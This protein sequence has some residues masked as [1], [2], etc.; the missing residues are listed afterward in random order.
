MVGVVNGAGLGLNYTSYTGTVN[1]SGVWNQGGLGLRNT[2][3]F[4]NGY[5]GN[6]IVQDQD[7]LLAAAGT[8]LRALRTYNSRGSFNDDNGD[9]W[10]TGVV[11]QSMRL[12]AGTWGAAGSTVLVTEEDGSERLYTWV[13]NRYVSTTSSG[14]DTYL[15]L[16][17]D[18]TQAVFS[19]GPQSGTFE[20]ATGRLLNWNSP[21]LLN[22]VFSYNANG[23]LAGMSAD[24]AGTG[25]RIVYEYNGDRLQRVSVVDEQN[26]AVSTTLYA[27]DANGRLS[28]VTV[29][30]SPSDGTIADGKVYTTDYT[31]VSSTDIT[32]GMLRSIVN[33]DGTSQTFKWVVSEGL[34]R[35]SQSW[36]GDGQIWSY[37]YSTSA[38]TLRVTQPGGFTTDFWYDG[39]G[40][41][42]QSHPSKGANNGV[43]NDTIRTFLEYYTTDNQATFT[44]YDRSVTVYNYD[45]DNNLILVRDAAGNTVRR[46][47]VNR[48]V[49]TETFYAVADPDGYGT[50]QPAGPATTRYVYDAEGKLRF[51]LS[52]EGAVT[53]LRYT[54]KLPTSTISYLGGAYNVSA[55]TITQTPTEAQMTTW[56]NG[57][58]KS[59]TSRVD[60]V[61]DLRGQKLRETAYAATDSS[62]NG[63][64]SGQ[65]VVVYAYDAA[66]RLL[67]MTDGSDASIT[68]AYDGLGRVL[69]RQ[70]GS[71]TTSYVHQDGGNGYVSTVTEQ[72]G[73]VTVSTYDK[74]G[75]LL[76]V[77][78]TQNGNALGTSTNYYNARG[79]LYKTQD[80]TGVFHW[81]LYDERANKVAEVDGNGTVTE[82]RYD[83]SQRPIQTIVYATPLAALSGTSPNLAW[84]DPPA[85][86][87]LAS[88]RPAETAKDQRSWTLYD[89]A[90]RP[91]R[92]VDAAG[93]VTE[94]QYDG[95]GRVT[96]T[97]RYANA[98]DLASFAANPTA[99][100]ATPAANADSDR[101]S[102]KFYSTEGRLLADLDAEGFLVEY[103]YDAA[104][105]LS[106]TVRYA[107][108]TPATLR[109]AGTL[110]Q[111]RPT[112]ASPKDQTTRYVYDGQSRVIG[113]I[114]AEG[115]VTEQLYDDR[116]HLVQRTRYAAKL[117]AA[118][119][120]AF[121][122][123]TGGWRPA[124][125][126]GV[127]GDRTE[128]W[129]YNTLGQ[130][131]EQTDADG[132]VTRRSYDNAG[133][134]ISTTRA[135]G[136]AEARTQKVRYDAVGRVVGELSARGA[137]L[138]VDGQTQAQVDA[139]W[140]QYGT[141]Y[142]Y[143]AAGRRTSQIVS[144]GTS[145]QRTIFFYNEDDQVTH[146]INA[147]GEVTENQYDGLGQLVK[148]VAYG[149]RLGATTLN[150]L[151]GGLA[152]AAIR[153]AVQ[154]LLA[155]RTPG[156][157]A[158][159]SAQSVFDYDARGLLRSTTNAL[160]YSTS[161]TYNAFGQA[162]VVS[163]QI[164]LGGALVQGK[165][166]YDRRGVLVAT[167]ADF[168]GLN[169]IT[170]T[171]VD[172]FGRVYEQLD[173]RGVLTKTGYDRLGRVV[174]TTDGVLVN[175]YTSYD[176][177][178]R[179]V[180]TTDGNGQKTTYRYDVA[181][182]TVEVTTPEGIRSRVVR[183]RHGEVESRTDG[184]NVTTSYAYTE[185]GELKT[186]TTP[187]NGTSTR[188]DSLG[189]VAE[190][191]DANGTVTKYAYDDLNRITSRTV[192][193]AGLNLITGYV[194]ED[195]DTGTTVLT[196]EADGRQT[197]QNF[198]VAGRLVSS[199]VDPSGLALTTR[200]ELDAEGRT[201]KVID[202]N[203]IVTRYE[204]DSLGRRT[205]EITDD[206]DSVSDLKLTRTYAYDAAG[207]LAWST[208]WAGARTLY[209]YDDANRLVYE[210][211]P[212]G[213]VR[214]TEYDGED[215][216]RRVARLAT[217]LSAANLTALGTQPTRAQIAALV[218]SA[219]AK[220]EISGRIYD[221]DGRVKYSVDAS[222]TVVEFRYDRAGRVTQQT[223]YATPVADM[224]AWMDGGAAAPT[225][226]V[227][228]R[229]TSTQ[230]D[231]LGR[232][233]V[234]VDAEG[235]VSTMVYD[236]AGNLQLRTSFAQPL[237]AAQQATLRGLGA[238]WDIVTLGL[239]AAHAQDR[240]T[241]YRYDSAGRPRY[242]YDAEGYVN[243]TR[244]DGL[245]TTT[246]R[247][248]EKAAV[249]VEPT[250]GAD[251]RTSLVELDK[252][253]RVLRS[254]DAMGVE[255]RNAYDAGGRLLA[256]TQAYGLAEATTT[257]YAYD[258]AGHVLRKTV[259]SGTGAA[260]TTGY[261][262]DSVGRMTTETEARGIAL[263]E[264][265]ETWARTERQRLGYAQ[266]VGGLSDT[267]K[268]T[269]LAR[270]TTTH[271]YDVAGRRKLTVNAMGFRTTTDYDAFG[272]AVKVTDPA[273]NAGYFYF[274]KLNRVTLQVDPEG[275]AT[276]TTYWGAGSSRVATVR[277]YFNKVGAPVVGQEPTIEEHAKDATTRHQYDRLDRTVLST[278][279][280]G[281]LER[282]SYGVDGN[283]FDKAVTN[284]ADG[285]AVYRTDRLGR[286]VS[287]TLPVSVLGQAVVNAYGY[288]AFDRTSS[289]EAVKPQGAGNDWV[290]RA[291]T[292][293]YDKAGRLTHRI[294]TGYEATDAATL[295]RST[296]VPVEFTR[297]D[298][299]GRVIET[300]QR[301][302][303]QSASATVVG[304]ARTLSYYDAASGKIAQVGADGAVTRFTLDVAG[305]VV[306]ESAFATRIAQPGIAG[307]QA[308]E[309]PVDAVNDRHTRQIYDALGR[310][311]LT[312]RENV[313]YW[314]STGVNDETLMAMRY[315]EVVTLK[316]QVYDAN[317][318]VVQEKDGRGGSIYNYY[319]STG[320][321]VLRID[322]AGYA[323]AWEF[324]DFLDVASRELKYAGPVPA[325]ARQD[326]TSAAVA[327]R[328][329]A[330]IRAGLSLVDAR[331]TDFDLDRLGR[332]SEKRVL[333][334]ETQYV[335]TDG[336]LR[337]AVDTA[338]T[339][340][341]YD[342]L[343]NITQIRERVAM[344][345]TGRAE[346]WAITD[347]VRDALGRETS[348]KA[349]RFVD[350]D[351]IE[352][353]QVT[354]TEYDGLGNARRVIQRGTIDVSE[355]DDRISRFEYNVNG[356]KVGEVDAAGNYTLYALDAMGN[357][358]TSTRKGVK[359]AD[360]S[361]YDI[362]KT[363]QYDVTGR[364][365]A[366]TDLA[367]S[368]V[369]KTRYNAFG[370]VTGKGLGDGWQE[371][372]EYSTL[373]KLQRGNSE[374]GIYKIHL[375]D[376]NGNAT[377]EISAGDARD[378][379]GQPI[380][381][382]VLGIATAA[383]DKRLNHSFSLYDARNLRTKT[384]EIGVSYLKNEQSKSF[385]FEQ[386]LADLYGQIGIKN[387]GGG[388]YEGASPTKDESG[389]KET[390]V[391]GA[392]PAPLIKTPAS[393]S[394]SGEIW[395]VSPRLQ[396]E[397][398]PQL[399]MPVGG[400]LTAPA[401]TTTTWPQNIYFGPPS[402]R[403]SITLSPQAPPL[404]GADSYQIIEKRSSGNITPFNVTPGVPVSL[405]GDRDAGTNY[406]LVAQYGTERVVLSELNVA[407]PYTAR[408]NNWE[409]TTR[410]TLKPNALMVT[411]P[412]A[413]AV[414]LRAYRMEGD[415]PIDISS[416]IVRPPVY[417][418]YAATWPQSSTLWALN[419][420]GLPDG[421]HT[422]VI[423]AED[424][425]GN[426]IA[427]STVTANYTRANGLVPLT[428]TAINNADL[429]VSGGSLTFK[430]PFRPDQPGDQIFMRVADHSQSYRALNN[431]GGSASISEMG[432]VNGAGYEMMIAKGNG[433]RYYVS[434]TGRNVGG[435]VVPDFGNSARMRTATERV[436]S[437]GSQL[438]FTLAIAPVDGYSLP[439]G[440]Q[441]RVE[442]VIG[443]KAWNFST[444]SATFEVSWQ[445][446]KD[447]QVPVN[448]L[449][450]NDIGFEY[451]V[452]GPRDEHEEWIG[453]SSGTLRA[454]TGP[455]AS[456]NPLPTLYVP[457]LSIPVAGLR[458][459][460][461]LTSGADTV[462]TYQ[463]T[464]GR[465]WRNGDATVLNLSDLMPAS[466]TA[467]Y[468]IT[469]DSSD[470]RFTGTVSVRSD[471]LAT[472]SLT[473]ATY[474]QAKVVLS[475]PYG[476]R[477]TR[478]D[479]GDSIL[480]LTNS[481]SRVPATGAS[482]FVWDVMRSEY[483]KTFDVYY[484]TSVG[485]EVSY[486]GRAKYSVDASGRV[487]F[488]A[489]APEFKLTYLS[490]DPPAET[491]SDGFQVEMRKRGS[492]DPWTSYTLLK[493]DPNSP[494][495]T[496]SLDISALRPTQDASVAYDFR[497]VSYA[498]GQTIV[499]K[500]AGGFVMYKDGTLI[501]DQQ[502]TERRP[503]PPTT[504]TGPAGRADAKTL[505]LSYTRVGTGVTTTVELTGAWNDTAKQM[506]YLWSAPMGGRVIES[507]EDYTFS[508]S[509]KNAGGAPLR[510]EVGDPI[511]YTGTLSVG[512]ARN[513][514]GMEMKRYVSTV[515]ASAKVEHRQTFNAFGEVAEEFD[516]RVFDRATAMVAQY[517]KDGLGTFAVNANAVRTVFKYNTLGQL[518]SKQ[519][520]ETFETLENGFVRRI[521]PLAQYGYD[522]L[523]RMT[524][525]T[526][527]NNHVSKQA[528]VGSSQQVAVQWAADN[529][530]R[531]TD[532]D[533][534]GDARKLTNELDK[535]TLQE[536]DQIGHLV[537][538]QR[539][540]ISRAENFSGAN[541]VGTV[542]TEEYKHDALGQ[543]IWHKDTLG[544]ED[545]TD[546]DTLSRVA[547]TW[548]AEG[549]ATRY[550]YRFVPAGASSDAVLGLGGRNVG[551]YVRKTISSDNAETTDKLDYFGRMT[552]HLDQG[553]RSYVYN[554]SLG[555]QLMSQT[556][557]G[558]QRIEYRY[559]LNG[560]LAEVRDYGVASTLNRGSLSRFGYDDAGNRTFEG[561]L[562]MRADGTEGVP[563]QAST[564]VY[565]ELNRI[566]RVHDGDFKSHD[567]RYEYDAV[568]NRRAVIATYWDPQTNSLQQRDD[569]WYTYD[570]AD[571]FTVTK[572]TLDRRGLSAGDTGT[573]ILLRTEGVRLTYDKAGQRTSA[574]QYSAALGR[575]ALEEYSYTADGYLEDTFID[576]VRR[577]RRRT[578]AEG[579][580]LQYLEWSA[581]SVPGMVKTSEYDKDN[582]VLRETVTGAK[583][584]SGLNGTTTFFYYGDYR[585]TNADAALSTGAGAMARA[586]F[587]DDKTLAYQAATSVTRYGYE[588]WDSAK[589]KWITQTAN[590]QTG[591]TNFSYDVN[592]H[593]SDVVDVEGGRVMTYYNNAQGMVL[594][595]TEAERGLNTPYETYFYYASGRRVGDVSTN[596]AAR[597]NRV[598]YAEQL[599]LK[600]KAP[601]QQQ[602]DYKRPAPV[603]SADFDQNY[604]PIN[605][606]YPSSVSSTYTV[607]PNDTLS[608]IAQSVWG[609]AAMWY[610]LAE[611]NGLSGSEVLVEGQVLVVPNKVTNIHNNAK[612]FRP[613]NPGEAIGNV[614]PTVPNPPPPPA[615]DKGCGAVGMALMIIVAVVVTV[616]TAGAGAAVMGFI[617]ATGT[618]ATI[619]A[620]A[621]SAALGA[622]A[623]QA[624]GMVTGDVDKFSWKAVGQAAL[625]AGVAAGV[626]SA[627]SSAAS[628]TGT[629]SS[630]SESA[631]WLGGRTLGATMARTAIS[632]AVT[633]AIQ[634]K[635]SWREVGASAVSAGAGYQAGLALQSVGQGM[636]GAEAIKN[637][638]GS[639]VGAWASSQVMGYNSAETRARLSQAFISGLGQ[640]IGNAIGDSIAEANQPAI[641]TL[642][643]TS[644]PIE[645]I[646]REDI[647]KLPQLNLQDLEDLKP[648]QLQLPASEVGSGGMSAGEFD[649]R[650]QS[651]EEQLRLE[652]LG[653][654]ARD[655]SVS[656][657]QMFQTG[658]AARGPVR[659]GI[660]NFE[661]VRNG[662]WD[663]ALNL[664]SDPLGLL[665][666]MPGIQSD[667]A[668]LNRIQ[669][670]KRIEGMREAMIGLGVKN[671]PSG[672]S[673][674]W[675]TGA[676]GVSKNVRD[677]GATMGQ[678]QGAY[679]GHVRDQRLRETWG[680]DYQNMRLGKSQMTVME[681]EKRVLDIQMATTDKAYAAGVDAI[682]RRELK[683][684]PGD[685]ARTLGSYI[686][687]Q[688]RRELRGFAR[689]EGINDNSTSNIWAI[690]RRITGEYGAG[691]PDNR[692]GFNLYSD[693]TLA[694]KGPW[695]EQIQ[696]WNWNRPGINLIIRPTDLGGAY[697][698]P[699]G[700]IPQ[701]KPLGRGI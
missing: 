540:G 554:Y 642:Q 410:V 165:F 97:V 691:I 550:E 681:F 527:A 257:A 296:V 471:G 210:I 180:D 581:S 630:V 470:A 343:G 128:F 230:Y 141:A 254:V 241:Q 693:T 395:T 73:L 464:D 277:R 334:V 118:Q 222:G 683:V 701:P 454:S 515:T 216:E 17:G 680:D 115:H 66:G 83:V 616:L 281:K 610:L 181:A 183:N 304:G 49:T 252:A 143:D 124:G 613:Y 122:A 370:E 32:N 498:A 273:G 502:T 462:R 311:V 528:F 627:I 600:E 19:N 324:K 532:Y 579:R 133:R 232:A 673:E 71:I 312:Q 104:G 401:P 558:G 204:Y 64:T 217:P 422:I 358:A 318:N 62:G 26:R 255:T 456:L 504:F 81:Y 260:S 72:N 439:P 699:R 251:D 132:T 179:V 548:S 646:T 597:K 89:A 15:T 262:Y 280:V 695:T 488:T 108:Q 306:K 361:T 369:R 87:T 639:T 314:E 647:G 620:A 99:V 151:S 75:R 601:V 362:V 246:I 497:Y 388:A 479:I 521:R 654:E 41:L 161:T 443:G 5:T 656:G 622:A 595:R 28:R 298:A 167:T 34:A 420:N 95:V 297:Y 697:V 653:Q 402:P 640:G 588:N 612:T 556:S 157:Q 289:V 539:L 418:Q 431:Y 346:V 534:F 7:G 2:Q 524:V 441:Y 694:R 341:D 78:R 159:A 148:T 144:D 604:E 637:A 14:P 323:I 585:D 240:T 263:T 576:G 223:A 116:G 442:A 270:F 65:H 397:N 88:I 440:K 351:G 16:S 545:R 313:W 168:G 287:E 384:V 199:T 239:P 542:V 663:A 194:Y 325:F 503:I 619:G 615:K 414:R 484:E 137:A 648:P 501:R 302:Q 211:D 23:S 519:D 564:I 552:W 518:I 22:A 189:R 55:L 227:N 689:A 375:Y 537:R 329:P 378:A 46:N 192:D 253:G 328:D 96:G 434:F 59:R 101:V 319:D 147:L 74:M 468:D 36:G 551:G 523:G 687:D 37:D 451:R 577:S 578:D 348:R 61:Y 4:I 310:L 389:L 9:N 221:R 606:G 48:L 53:E 149:G 438:K 156:N 355:T 452:Y 54:G 596:P 433:Q 332:V 655:A 340:Y 354:D 129:H 666:E 493:T 225:E 555:G 514:S 1:Q 248:A 651:V 536:F 466:G 449:S 465:R 207:R 569:F 559:L 27:Y 20:V 107:D 649:A 573:T 489:A 292:Y 494:T 226:G 51:K 472:A 6:L 625:S 427:A 68:Y 206:G 457:Y 8:D 391:G 506:E 229:V 234:T 700:S 547:A 219:P 333:N 677:Y 672:Y 114:D 644:T 220:D 368:E 383:E 146:T 191:T 77:T 432:L 158:Y 30:L 374:E 372:S 92:R 12:T 624:A 44:D 344:A 85:A 52:P 572:G 379:G 531:K 557:S 163:R 385:A 525:S 347:I 461:T 322:Q 675:V 458:G 594:K 307:G 283:R 638:L 512:G 453:Y 598:S 562:S 474:G 213:A 643:D 584:D 367:T 236:G 386:K 274:D 396:S 131:D 10:I 279:A 169:A 408:N 664:A 538:V 350:M 614:D 203:G 686:D 170:R 460:I 93:F 224:T 463:E 267:D 309:V 412:P 589:Q 526:D 238:G 417:V 39:T 91:T 326:D 507:Q 339:G 266:L 659:G 86:P 478:L 652:I 202:P 546:F 398:Y 140:A 259:A 387:T 424:A 69:T 565:D 193:P 483:G 208:D 473:P 436:G 607:R 303:W 67:T 522:L 295:T 568:G 13:T 269:L 392:T 499:S 688:V 352:R 404:G 18:G 231:A 669:A 154:E 635:W 33:S 423:K 315:A 176:A 592:G 261:G 291:T 197:R 195:T 671:V 520:P 63:L 480:T 336:A 629:A 570:E 553:G 171:R 38:R 684:D 177:F 481:L 426:V 535:V 247:H 353:R 113:E 258:Q 121:D 492:Q 288:D 583:A 567:V 416:A 182:R 50:G 271:E 421:S 184:N 495:Q 187:L 509:M 665:G 430:S 345:A 571:R 265:D 632:S 43:T 212:M 631:K 45:A 602:R 178:S 356:D 320:R 40:R 623:S 373:G 198:D 626:S 185:N 657:A 682:A 136:S 233:V 47:F 491:R 245:K 102:R 437:D 490:F 79:L 511:G 609:D 29:D 667:L 566:S 134:V 660:G 636:Q 209:A 188:Y 668:K 394:T 482:P 342:G 153:N 330:Q 186:T 110:A 580:T 190:T 357:A 390:Q 331:I 76:G 120:A 286:T 685:Y 31:Y 496:R 284:K 419:F 58:D 400:W 510:D 293:R 380:D 560:L 450:V 399:P 84:A 617:G 459:A 42:K 692:L 382:S 125:T 406:V 409:V 109:A 299:L 172:A 574:R 469:Y 218:V 138:L 166:E 690:N 235:G 359:R 670:E 308:P 586:E 60:T 661:M 338:I 317:G 599:A 275:Y 455:S 327:L 205:A 447:L 105:R 24:A 214:Y 80:P 349:P 119:I 278:D 533:I 674:S 250:L 393:P 403:A 103:R 517:N 215:R 243:E 174:Q 563:Y 605:A 446:L 228:D 201:L 541:A 476:G 415:T 513:S 276:R 508:M 405:P 196:T 628:S 98:I 698:I 608:S 94:T 56:V 381:L 200:F 425:G 249:G 444:S 678:L 645:R 321:K 487:T 135:A 634:G 587:R 411:Q 145:T 130:L 696:K 337:A 477:L 650:R 142:T 582:R 152:N 164:R 360:S 516:Q 82:F 593:Q 485:S 139:I 106:A 160:G 272:N 377:R 543:R 429:E 90:G 549:R 35:I 575:E 561:Y 366:E 117:A 413:G 57:A 300:I 529:G 530:R 445:T 11:R 242:E 486:K 363:F 305:H 591:R 603:T 364:V 150:G 590:G 662:N 175:R 237:N 268:L 264:S 294:G 25:G 658:G 407:N 282:V 448:A 127:G 3:I 256:Q 365:T 676:D 679:E 162:D 112:T 316:E 611:A 505:V 244:Y 371:T 467:T 376:R 21:T 123:G 100:N 285:Q 428:N 633:Q 335:D 475:V 544:F 173:A 618:T 126:P 301:G 155:Q 290:S 111:L 435:V 641:K 500:G 621:V 70:Q